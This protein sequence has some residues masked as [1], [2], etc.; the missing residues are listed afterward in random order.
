[1]STRMIELERFTMQRGQAFDPH[2]HDAHQLI[3]TPDGILAVELENRY[4]MLPTTLALWVPAGVPHSPLALR[5]SVMEG[6][7]LD[8]GSATNGW[9]HPTAVRISPLA[10]QLIAH[11][12][13]P[14]EALQRDRAEAVL[15]DV[16]VP[17]GTA[18]IIVP[19]PTDQRAAAVARRILTDPADQRTLADYGRDVGASSRT[20]LRTFLSDTGLPFS[21]W[22]THARLQAA[23]G[24]LAE[25]H[26]VSQAAYQV[27]YS[28]PSAFIAAFRR[29][30]GQ[31]P[32]AFVRR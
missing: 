11:L 24:M 28:T 19:L 8:A 27:G 2:S 29:T 12:R 6:I 13:E 10:R 7:Y 9:D 17:A 25:G 18:S 3:W 15:M 21:T 30:T 1:M 20:L 14:L 4:W 32:G 5:D 22:R 26:T 31:T 16:L 23:V